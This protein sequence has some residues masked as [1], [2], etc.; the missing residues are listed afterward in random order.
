MRGALAARGLDQVV[1]TGRGRGTPT[2]WREGPLPPP[3]R[4]TVSPR[5]ALMHGGSAARPAQLGPACAGGGGGCLFPQPTPI[6]VRPHAAF[7]ATESAAR[8]YVAT[9]R[10]AAVGRRGAS[11]HGVASCRRDDDSDDIQRPLHCEAF[12]SR[13]RA[14]PQ[15]SLFSSPRPARLS[16]Y[17][18]EHPGT[19]LYQTLGRY[20]PLPAPRPARRSWRVFA[21]AAP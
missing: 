19:K 9:Q 5:G 2:E 1:W 16:A 4:L 20:Q 10:R 18:H 3:L 21:L 15:S 7:I 6:I 12:P 13:R 17:L 14:R 11:R 8:G